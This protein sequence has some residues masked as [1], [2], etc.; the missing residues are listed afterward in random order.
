MDSGSGRWK[1]WIAPISSFKIGGEE[2]H[3]TRLRIG[4]IG[5]DAD[6]L[7]GADFFLA[8]HIYVSNRQDKLY[9]TYNGGPVFNLS[10]SPLAQSGTASAAEK[11]PRS[12]K[13][14]P[15]SRPTPRPSAG[16]APHTL[17]ASTSNMRS[18]I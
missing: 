7:L 11:R 17:H 4:D 12:P 14:G 15:K 16:A 13:R 1:T 9:F 10:Q 18:R 5:P 3:D 6:M 2:I 8:H